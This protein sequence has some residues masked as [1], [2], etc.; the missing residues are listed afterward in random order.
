MIFEKLVSRGLA[1]N[2]YLV[3][4]GDEAAVI[5]PRRD[6]DAYLE[7][8]R[9]NDLR[10]TRV[11]ETHRNE[12]YVIGSME[13]ARV[14]GCEIH[15]GARLDFRY[16][17]PVHEGDS[18]RVGSLELRILETPGHTEE[19]ISIVLSD[20]GVSGMPLMVFTG[21]ALF[22]GEVGRTDFYPDRP[23]QV[24]G[25]LYHSLHQKILPLGDG[26]IVC[27]A[28]GGGSVCGADIS[29]LPL[30]TIGYEKE[31][32]P[33][34]RLERGAFIRRK[35]AERH[36]YPPYFSMMER[37]NRDGP[38][39]LPCPLS[40]PG[41][42]VAAVKDLRERGA[43]VVDIRSP[44]SFAGGHVPGSLHI[45]REGLSAFAG[46]F[47]NYEDPIVLIDDFNQD[48]DEIR[49][50]FG[51]LGY[52]NFAG[53]LGGGGFMAWAKAAEPLGTVK[54]WTVHDLKEYLGDPTL[55]LLDLRDEPNYRKHGHL[56]GA[57]QVYAGEF[58]SFICKVPEDRR[59]VC[60]CDSGYKSSIAASLLLQAGYQDVIV[61]LGSMAAWEK[62]GY[63]VEREK[64]DEK[65]QISPG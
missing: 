33:L 3:G 16:G 6:I 57:H 37:L 45:W 56:P 34:L 31:T 62:A 26:V 20:I 27:P 28:H 18:F 36:H 55:Y 41:L 13:L 38:P 5:D 29:D 22:A 61:V 24:A 50:Q 59:I 47:L 30:T 21:D 2:S 43:Q 65:E 15:H 54:T 19:S 48:L 9:R 23:E 63:P 53:C 12:D 52:D 11:F 10:I 25:E 42:T 58:R 44:S 51:R 4:A 40:V 35:I 49:R 1:H 17:K 32:N 64:E 46:Y 14:T 39:P 7:I 8:A 60:F